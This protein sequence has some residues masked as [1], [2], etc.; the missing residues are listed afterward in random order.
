MTIR[1]ELNSGNDA[2]GGIIDGPVTFLSTVKVIV[3]C[4]RGDVN[5]DG[6]VSMDDLATLTNYLL[7]GQGLNAWQLE[8]A[9]MNGDGTVGM[10][11]LAILMQYLLN[12][13]GLSLDEL[14]QILN[15]GTQ[16]S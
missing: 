11:D 8:A 3:G 16:T 12:Y 4:R 2:R 14:E 13:T 9:D 15:G 10:D 1:G 5:D 6:R 7:T